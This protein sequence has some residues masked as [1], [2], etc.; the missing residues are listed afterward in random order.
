MQAVLFDIDGVIYQGDQVIPGARKTI[1]WFQKR[2]IPHLFVTNTSSIPR[3]ALAEKLARAGI[4]TSEDRILTPAV[5]AKHWIKQ[6]TTGPVALFITES[7]QSEFKGLEI[8]EGQTESGA[9][10][11]VIGDLGNLWTFEK[12]NQAF[13]LLMAEPHPALLALGMTRYWHTQNGLQ[14][15]VAPFVVAL[16]HA[17]GAKAIVVGKPAT[18]FFDSALEILGSPANQTVM[19]GDDIRGDVKGALDAGLNAILVRT[20]KFRQNDLSQGIEPT[21]VIVSIAGLPDWWMGQ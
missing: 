1:A 17:S 14:L 9:A 7:T 18:E 11:I 12:L 20:G 15:D 10:A 5:T 4:D 8:L 6:H 16:E 3:S 2:K 21:A 19:I 13:R